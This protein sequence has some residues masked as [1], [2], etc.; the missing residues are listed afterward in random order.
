MPK[1][2]RDFLGYV[3]EVCIACQHTHH[4]ISFEDFVKVAFVEMVT[5]ILRDN[6]IP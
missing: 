6:G 2:G 1:V 3:M 5:A 4:G